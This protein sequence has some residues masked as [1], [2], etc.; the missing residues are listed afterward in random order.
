[1][2]PALRL[3][4]AAWVRVDAACFRRLQRFGGPRVS[5]GTM[6]GARALF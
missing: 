1:M 3:F 2:S 5:R 6:G 4:P